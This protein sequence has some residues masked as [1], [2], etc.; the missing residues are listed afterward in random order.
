MLGA[1]AVPVAAPVTSPTEAEAPPHTDD[2]P[3]LKSTPNNQQFEAPFGQPA[4]KAQAGDPAAAPGLSL[5]GSASG[6]VDLP[7]AKAAPAGHA[8]EA[9]DLPAPKAARP[10]DAGAASAGI[11]L[12]APKPAPAAGPAGAAGIGDV[13]LP[14]PKGGVSQGSGSGAID[15]PAPKQGSASAS[16]FGGVDLPAPKPGGALAPDFGG[17]DLPAPKPGGAPA[18][19]FGGVDL[20]APKS[21]GALAPEFGGADGGVDLPAP[22]QSGDVGFGDID[23]PGPKATEPTAAGGLGG[24]DQFGDLDLPAPK[25]AADPLGAQFG[26][27]DLPTPKS[28][29]FDGVDLPAARGAADLP[30]AKDAA[31]LPAPAPAAM[32]GFGD[33]DLPMPLADAD[34][35]QPA[36]TPTDLPTPAQ[37]DATFGDIELPAP[38]AAAD[39]V[40]PKART[41]QGVG[42]PTDE[43]SFGD[44]GLGDAPAG[45]AESELPPSLMSDDETSFGD[46]DLGDDRPLAPPAPPIP[47]SVGGTSGPLPEPLAPP[48]LDHGLGDAPPLIDHDGFGGGDFGEQSENFGEVDFDGD[49][50]EYDEDDEEMEFGIDEDEEGLSLP[51][52]ILRR[53]R[54]EGLDSS[55]AGGRKRA[56]LLVGSVFAFVLLLGLAGVAVGMFTKYGYFAIYLVEQFLPEAGTPQFARD[57]TERAEKLAASD[58]YH[59]IRRSLTVLGEARGKFGLNRT[60]L[61]RSLVHESLYLLRFGDDSRAASR[62]GA[63]VRRLQER[64]WDAPGIDL[65][66]AAEAARHGR[67]DEAQGFFE[68]AGRASESDPYLWLLRGEVALAQNKLDDA[69]KA[70]AA[71]LKVGGKARAQWGLAR[72]ARRRGDPEPFAS[73]VEATLQSSPA[74]V[75]ARVA[76]ARVAWRRGREDRAVNLLR[77][78]IGLDPVEDGYLWTSQRTLAAAHSLMGYIHEERG[79]LHHARGSYEAAL[80]ANPTRLDA[81]LGAGRVL[82]RERR[83]ADALARFETAANA[84]KHQNERL[85]SGRRADAEAALG[86]GRAL[87]RL[88]RAPL[89]KE[90]LSALA[91]TYPDDADIV[92]ALGDVEE[93]LGDPKEAEALYRKSIELEPHV[94]DGYLALSQLFFRQDMAD[95][96]SEALNEAATQVEE[97]AEMRRMLGN[98]ELARNR[99]SSAIHEFERALELDPQDMEAKFG[100]GQALR[101]DGQLDRARNAFDQIGHQDPDFAGLPLQRGLLYEAAGAFDEAVASYRTALEKDPEDVQLLLRLGAA[102]VSASDLDA[103]EQTLHKV[104]H[105]MHNSPE[106]EYFIGRIAFA[107][108]R[109]PDALTHFNRALTHDGTNGEFHLYASRANLA[110]GNIGKALEEAELAIAR[111]PSLGDAYWVRGTVRLRMGAVKDALRDLRT[112]IKLNPSRIEAIASM[113]ECFDQMREQTLAVK[114]FKSALKHDPSRGHWWYRLAEINVDRGDRKVG[115]S[116]LKKAIELGA[117]EETS[118]FWLPSAYRLAGRLAEVRGNRKQAIDLYKRYLAV[119]PDGD[120]DL[121]DVKKRMSQWG[122]ELDERTDTPF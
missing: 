73:G 109:T 45:G 117:K 64:S 57:A 110:L 82:L 118:P 54:G 75:A 58:T 98:S 112:A 70:F 62:A 114:A 77:Q 87:I 37:P 11:D 23:L 48:E 51:P 6:A 40:Q 108:G 30:A 101:R 60:L 46:I 28:P 69:D 50:D 10:G 5:A 66:R 86:I 122:V 113:G 20:P 44:L 55:Q 68:A 16:D 102:Q 67:W 42:V 85:V 38:L 8:F 21:G 91:G 19:D 36:G 22:R 107:R 121:D 92:R 59:D 88:E 76:D 116:H 35:P 65:A 9:L 120:L 80:K 104:I 7:A 84:A 100:M 119:A 78:A 106:A 49:D 97:T 99:L 15:L 33:L 96:A 26:G 83:Y 3:A 105:R 1:A 71:A 41:V 27:L 29:G 89:A 13:D 72:V 14:A 81:L 17:V 12:P 39:L 79:R 31:D 34:L 95:K 94:F 90:K 24:M 43:A 53:Q 52:E 115:Q 74:H 103:A 47:P 56:L 4:S 93:A 25:A 2:L 63:I 61:A 111:D 18:P 32:D